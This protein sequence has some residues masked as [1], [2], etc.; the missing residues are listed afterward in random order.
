MARTDREGWWS[1]GG[2]ARTMMPVAKERF[3]SS[4]TEWESV[5]WSRDRREMARGGQ[6]SR[7]AEEE[8]V[9]DGEVWMQQAM[10]MS[11][12]VPRGR[13]RGTVD[14][15]DQHEGTLAAVRA[16]QRGRFY[17]FEGRNRFR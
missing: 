11:G 12:A 1:R 3:G 13:C 6:K 2:R 8:S 16:D 10:A 4:T 15:S 5:S 14:D 7:R 9:S 17:G